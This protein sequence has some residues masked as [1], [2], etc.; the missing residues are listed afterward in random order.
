MGN[1]DDDGAN[2][3]VSYAN[4]N[5]NG[6]AKPTTPISNGHIPNHTTFM[7]LILILKFELEAKGKNCLP[8]NWR[9]TRLR[10]VRST[11]RKREGDKEEETVREGEGDI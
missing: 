2:F 4:S 8:S 7:L 5:G 1:L 3:D 9:I 10:I 11:V 6:N